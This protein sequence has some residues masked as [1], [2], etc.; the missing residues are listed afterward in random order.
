MCVYL[1]DFSRLFILPPPS[2][3]PSSTSAMANVHSQSIPASAPSIFSSP[4]SQIQVPSFFPVE[5]RSSTWIYTAAVIVLSLLALEQGVYRYKK[6]HLP[7]SK[8]TIPI[9]GKFADSLNPTMEG[10]IRQWNS[11]ALSAL[12]VFNMYVFILLLLLGWLH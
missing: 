4:L 2:F 5:G 9:I 1:R 12:S 10:Y 11:G 8:W 3:L 6:S 7:G